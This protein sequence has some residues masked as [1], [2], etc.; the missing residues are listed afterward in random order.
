MANA[1][2]A[3]GACSTTYGFTRGALAFGRTSFLDVRTYT[4]VRTEVQCE[5]VGLGRSLPP[6]TKDQKPKHF[7]TLP[8]PAHIVGCARNIASD[9]KSSAAG[10]ESL[11]RAFSKYTILIWEDGSSDGT[12]AMLTHWASHNPRVRMLGPPPDVKWIGAS[13]GRISRLAF[14]RQVLLAESLKLATPHATTTHYT[15]P[16]YYIVMDLDCPTPPRPQALSLAIHRH[17][18]PL[19]PTKHLPPVAGDLRAR[20]ARAT[21]AASAAGSAVAHPRFD[22]LLANSQPYYYDLLVL[23]S[24]SLTLQY[25]CIEDK[26]AMAARGACCDYTITIDPAAPPIEV[27]SAFNGLAVYSL[28][29]LHDSGCRYH[30][31]L[32]READHAGLHPCLRRA[33]LRLAIAPS[34]VHGCGQAHTGHAG[35]GKTANEIAVLRNGTFVVRRSPLTAPGAT[36]STHLSWWTAWR[37]DILDLLIP[38]GTLTRALAWVS[39]AVLAAV[40]WRRARQRRASRKE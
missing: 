20:A 10:I 39:T 26:A 19:Q 30:G 36:A 18:V 17:M 35:P 5:S 12:R 9:L 4:G 15:P 27:D 23:R 25:D 2:M 33:G 21:R 37:Y 11:G 8:E 13:L 6:H 16:G 34:I 1:T 38:D 3:N 7:T 22:A 32:L 14:G 40:A 29:A 24:S 28:A 31:P